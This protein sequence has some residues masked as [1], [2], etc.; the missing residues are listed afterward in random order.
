[1]ETSPALFA[2]LSCAALSIGSAATAT[3]TPTATA[4]DTES[5]VP[6]SRHRPE[7]NVERIAPLNTSDTYRWQLAADLAAVTLQ[8]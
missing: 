4:T 2:L 8:E 1:M 6:A 7:A 3:T 5:G